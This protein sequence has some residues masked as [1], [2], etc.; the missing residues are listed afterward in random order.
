MT[1]S[2]R[3]RVRATL[4]AAAVACCCI[5]LQCVR[6]VKKIDPNDALQSTDWYDLVLERTLE[7]QPGEPLLAAGPDGELGTADDVLHAYIAGDLDL[8]VRSGIQG[9]SGPIPPPTALTPGGAVPVAVAEPLGAG[10]TV[11]FVVVASDGAAEPAYGNVASPAYLEGLPLLVL[12]FADLDGDGY[13]GVTNLDGDPLDNSVEEAELEPVGRRFAIASAGQAAGSLAVEV[14]GPPGAEIDVVLAA[15]G[16][17]GPLDPGYMGGNVPKGPAVMTA[18]P[19]KPRTDPLSILPGGA[20]HTPLPSS[21][22]DLVGVQISDLFT[23]DPAAIYGE[24]YT[25]ELD[26]LHPSNDRATLAAGGFSRFG[27]ATTPDP[28]IFEAVAG[29]SLRR[30]LDAAGQPATFVV[31]NRVL[32]RDDGGAGETAV[33]VVPLDRLGNVSDLPAPAL[34]SLVT[35]GGVRIVSPD[36]DGDPYFEELLVSDPRGVEVLLDDGG[37]TFDDADSDRLVVEGAGSL[38]AIDLVLPDP[39]VDD[40]GIVDAADQALVAAGSG[41]VGEAADPRLDL[42]GNMRIDERD[43]ALVTA[44]LGQSISVP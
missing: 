13:V 32:V 31:P 16:W 3:P 1:Y 19:I 43:L 24:T 30:G 21:P 25:L 37:L 40:S 27:I 10:S 5:A 28:T 22:L 6:Y 35:Q 9:F 2:T 41:S 8:V 38:V 4:V 34:V 44:W 14:G 39:D 12:A 36:V 29:R 17:A 15:A 33:R 26:A 11:D 42:D 20:S 7:L 23:P 18:L